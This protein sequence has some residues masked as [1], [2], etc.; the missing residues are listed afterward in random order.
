MWYILRTAT[1][2]PRCACLSNGW[3]TCSR[4]T[5]IFKSRRQCA[6]LLSKRPDMQNIVF[7]DRDSLLATVRAPAF[8]HQWRDY[9]ATQPAQVAERLAGAT[10]AITNKVPVRA[11]DLA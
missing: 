5:R 7:L 10:I 4:R 6:N 2:R 1:C 8:E 3:R 9:P 11:A